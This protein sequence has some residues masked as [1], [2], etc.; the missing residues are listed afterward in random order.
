MS[1]VASGEGLTAETPF[2][3]PPGHVTALKVSCL[4]HVSTYIG[5]ECVIRFAC[6]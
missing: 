5:E 2:P 6:I 4:G 1:I 3:R